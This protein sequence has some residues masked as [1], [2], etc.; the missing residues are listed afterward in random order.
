MYISIN[1]WLVFPI[2]ELQFRVEKNVIQWLI[3]VKQNMFW[4]K[5]LSLQRG[6]HQQK[7]W[8]NLQTGF[9]W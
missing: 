9:P 3:A 8:L 5:M 1:G 7:R 2:E 6:Q 4:S